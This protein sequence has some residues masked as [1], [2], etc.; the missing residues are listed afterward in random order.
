M[1]AK[2]IV[3]L[4]QAWYS[5][6]E[7]RFSKRLLRSRYSFDAQDDPMRGKIHIGIETPAIIG[8][9]T[10]WNK[11][12]VDATALHKPSG[13]L[14]I[15][16]DRPLTASDDVDVLLDSYFKTFMKLETEPVDKWTFRLPPNWSS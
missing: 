1:T 2:L 9:V 10:F 6:N 4:V 11:G 15:I 5:Q 12:D 7:Q 14:I 13:R 8:S 16:D 3:P